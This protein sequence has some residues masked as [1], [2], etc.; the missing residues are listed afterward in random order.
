M[1]PLPASAA[2]SGVVEER[3]RIATALTDEILK[4]LVLDV[5]IEEKLLADRRRS[6]LA[7]YVPSVPLESYGT[8]LIEICI[9]SAPSSGSSNGL[10]AVPNG[11]NGMSPTPSPSKKDGDFEC[12]VCSRQVRQRFHSR[13]VQY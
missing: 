7:V 5:V 2:S 13:R 6:R 11:T 1:A 12:L 4:E 10:L 9:C 8:E 3:N